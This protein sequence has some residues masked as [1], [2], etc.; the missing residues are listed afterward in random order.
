M[1]VKIGGSLAEWQEILQSRNPHKLTLLKFAEG[2]PKTTKGKWV[3]LC[4][5]HGEFTQ[6][7]SNSLKGMGCKPCSIT[8]IT[9]TEED[10][11]VKFTKQHG[12]RYAYKFLPGLKEVEITC[13]VAGHG[14]FTQGV[15][16]HSVGHGC[17]KCA[18][19]RV[20]ALRTDSI[21]ET[22]AKVLAKNSAYT[23]VEVIT[24]ND[25][26]LRM[27]C[28]EHGEF[29]VLANSFLTR[30]T[31]CPSCS[32]INRITPLEDSP[33]FQN[34][35]DELVYS[36]R[37]KREEL[38]LEQYTYRGLVPIK[39]NGVRQAGVKR[40]IYTTC[41][42]HGEWEQTVECALD[43]KSCALC[44]ARVRGIGL[45]SSFTDLVA[46]A[47][48]IHKNFYT[49]V[50]HNYPEPG[51]GQGRLEVVCPKHGRFDQI[52]S[53]HINGQG[54]PK[55]STRISSQNVWLLDTLTQAG[56]KCEGEQAISTLHPTWRA[57]V[58]V[59][60]KQLVIE[61]LGLKWHSTEFKKSPSDSLHRKRELAKDG[62]RSVFLY[63]DE[64]NKRKNAVTALILRASGVIGERKFARNTAAVFIALT[65]ANE[66][67]EK[68]H[69]Q[70]SVRSGIAI[71][72][73][74]DSQLVAVAVF[75]ANTST[76][77]ANAEGCVELTRYA[78]AMSVAGGLSKCI[79]AFSRAYKEVTTV[80]SFSEDRLFTGGAYCVVGFKKLYTTA[81]DYMYVVR[82]RRVHK[83][84]FQ[85]SKLAKMFPEEDMS[86][87]E[88]EITEKHK[89]YRIYD[90]GKTKWELTL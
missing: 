10:W 41:P 87:S 71:G 26:Q 13:S 37:V 47:D 28:Q 19:N 1:A 57:D 24:G 4:P 5:A 40:S 64:V 82:S 62:Y 15:V 8:R 25:R 78:T 6:Y 27:L 3:L 22:T 65:I 72:L 9:Y 35:Y 85:K 46:R 90:C 68:W 48:N 33:R 66:F 75:N 69:I 2:S 39:E 23:L 61:H 56:V 63:E 55:C 70:G 52:I 73:F 17:P 76:R 79:K 58:C 59:H 36:I 81:P 51:A 7:V 86:L 12:D 67:L 38:G 80:Q 14:V 89:I 30:G 29:T 50:G 21:E 49:Y 45:R 88:K 83:S 77:K 42:T 53:N 34:Y 18:V 60:D 31:A 32:E 43:G 84:N 54:C 16:S 44:S 20:A 74:S 11:R